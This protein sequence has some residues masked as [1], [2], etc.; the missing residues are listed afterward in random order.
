VNVASNGRQFLGSFGNLGNDRHCGD[1]GPSGPQRG[2][3]CE[4]RT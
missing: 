4:L 2:E 3:N 1:P